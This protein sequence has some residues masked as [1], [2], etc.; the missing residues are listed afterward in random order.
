M[1]EATIYSS[2]ADGV[3]SHHD[4]DWA[5]VRSAATGSYAEDY[6][7]RSTQSM[8]A[9][10]TS[11][12]QVNIHRSFFYFDL[13]EL[14]ANVVITS[15]TL[16]L[17][18]YYHSSGVSAQE[19]TQG[20]SLTENDF[21]AFIGSEFGHVAFPASDQYA[22]I[23]FNDVGK[24]YIS[25]KMGIGV[26]KVCCR[27]YEHDYLNNEPSPG[28][29]YYSGCYFADNDGT[30]KD[31]KLVINYDFPVHLLNTEAAAGPFP[32]SRYL[33]AS[34]EKARRVDINPPVLWEETYPRKEQGGVG[35]YG[36]IYIRI[37]D[38]ESGIDLNTMEFTVAGSTYTYSNS[39]VSAIPIDPPFS[40]VVKFVPSAPW[41]LGDTI[42]VS[43]F[44]RDKAGNPGLLE[45]RV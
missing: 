14:P 30:D 11:G 16:Q 4:G 28:T 44:V 33:C 8:R 10:K 5:T 26:A 45:L 32:S 34:I 20:A 12:G 41:E 7:S 42:E 36:P 15:V 27:E 39:E 35:R 40:Y 21:D 6:S 18:R 2:I 17:Y 19:G 24:S 3:V 37:C 9:N 25:A 38:F 31:P 23:I 22:S 1:P 29:T 13:S 43:L